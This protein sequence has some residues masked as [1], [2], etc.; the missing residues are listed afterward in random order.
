MAACLCSSVARGELY[1]MMGKSFIAALSPRLAETRA[2]D[3]DRAGADLPRGSSTSSAF[4]YPR[5]AA[6]NL[7]SIR[8][9]AFPSFFLFFASQLSFLL[10]VVLPSFFSLPSFF[11]TSSFPSLVLS[12]LVVAGSRSPSGP[13]TRR[14]VEDLA[15]G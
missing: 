8:R 2:A 4:T 11:L 14:Q 3:D 5:N 9:V 10:S 1:W 15:A 6:W 7:P 13:R 12:F